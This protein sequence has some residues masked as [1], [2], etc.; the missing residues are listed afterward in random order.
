[1]QTVTTKVEGAASQLKDVRLFR[2]ACYVD[3]QWIQAASGQA[4]G[5]DNPAT[6]EIIGKVPK[7]GGLETR[8]AIVAANRAFPACHKKTA[9][10]RAAILRR[11][12]YVLIVI[13]D[14]FARRMT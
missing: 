13:H 7:L 8:R 3:G 1:M 5:V 14:D 4:I 2:E 9:K 12:F 10:Q 11:W 6:G